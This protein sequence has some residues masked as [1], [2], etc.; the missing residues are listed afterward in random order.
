MTAFNLFKKFD[1]KICPECNRPLKQRKE[2]H[3]SLCDEILET[4]NSEDYFKKN[5]SYLKYLKDSIKDSID[6]ITNEKKIQ[7]EL[8]EKQAKLSKDIKVLENLINEKIKTSKTPLIEKI[9]HVSSEISKKEE[10]IVHV[11]RNLEILESFQHELKQITELEDKIKT[12]RIKIKSINEN[13]EE[14]KRSEIL[15]KSLE[16]NLNSF[17]NEINYPGFESIFIDKNFVV[18]INSKNEG[19][20]TIKEIRSASNKII[21]RLGL[22]YALLKTALENS[23]IKHPRLVYLDSPRDQELKWNRFCNSL[24]KFRDLSISNN[25]S[26]QIFI[27]VVEDAENKFSNEYEVLNEHVF[28]RLSNEDGHRLLRK[29]EK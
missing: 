5:M 4:E 24:L 10:L 28:M 13:I 6:V 15:L 14:N 12:M 26:G 2:N 18:R 25:K 1:T 16:N 27:T 29:K 19:L 8:K 9:S 20:K 21:I 3:C 17:F 11:D 7:D 22:F 23:E